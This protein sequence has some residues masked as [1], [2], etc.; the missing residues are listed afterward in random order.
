MKNL[1]FKIM[2]CLSLVLFLIVGIMFGYNKETKKSMFNDES[3]LDYAIRF[4]SADVD[5]YVV[6]TSTKV[7]DIEVIYEDCYL[8]CNESESKSKMVYGTT[9]DKVKEDEEK[10]Q[11]AKGVIYEIKGESSTRI[12][13]SR[14]INGICP[15][16][17]F[18]KAE[19]GVV[20]VYRIKGEDKKEI[21]T[22]LENINIENLRQELKT[23]IEKG[24]YLNSREELNHFIEDLES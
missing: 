14:N 3:I 6:T 18:V 15:N 9:M 4:T 11:E 10:E 12:M 7:S 24:T 5:N 21:Y 16:H 23:K 22:K 19:S 8:E 2:Y 17:Y 13:Y 1:K 20:T